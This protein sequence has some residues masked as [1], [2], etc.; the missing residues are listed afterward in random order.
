[1][2]FIKR[3]VIPF[4]FIAMVLSACSAPA[5]QPVSAGEP[6]AGAGQASGDAAAQP[7]ATGAPSA[8]PTGSAMPA[9]ATATAAPAVLADPVPLELVGQGSNLAGKII[10]Y[11]FLVRNPN[12]AYLIESSGFRTHFYDANGA[13]LG[14]DEGTIEL[15][16]PGQTTGIGSARYLDAGESIASMKIELN[17][18]TPAVLTETLPLY[19]FGNTSECAINGYPVVRTEITSPYGTNVILPR[20]SVVFYDAEGKIS[21]GGYGYR[22]GILANGKTGVVITSGKT[23]ATTRYE[24]YA[25]YRGLPGSAALPADASPLQV[26]AQ[27]FV[28]DGS[29]WIY[30]VV[31]ENPNAAYLV[32]QSLLAINAYAPDGRFLSGEPQ[33]L[34]SVLP[35]QKLGVSRELVLC[36]GD[37]VDHIEVAISSGD[38]TASQQTAYFASENVSLQGGTVSGDL[39]NQFSQEI[40]TVIATAI[41]YDANGQI[42]GGGSKTVETIAAGG[43]AAV[44]IPVVV[45]GTPARAELYGVLTRRS[46]GK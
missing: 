37:A 4:V 10:S 13:E 29:R 5:G 36:D 27:A 39:V 25:G 18:G 42:I 43:R 20:V 32:D 24:I 12:P 34:I 26:S 40:K 3:I 38:Y 6:T 8:D 14:T 9:A 7:A 1:M 31:I 44:Q 19:E 45:N 33:P 35:G 30:S 41:V 15:V 2:N 22:A 46:L 11:S 21:G 17:S 23:A 28:Q 16:L